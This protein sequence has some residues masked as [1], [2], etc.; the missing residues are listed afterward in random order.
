[1][2]TPFQMWLSGE[3]SLSCLDAAVEAWH[4]QDTVVAKDD[5][6]ELELFEAWWDRTFVGVPMSDIEHDTAKMAWM[7]RAALSSDTLSQ[8]LGMSKEEF[9]LFAF[10]PREFEAKY[11]YGSV[12]P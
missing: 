2:K 7:Q 4:E 1:M 3:G 12:K 11:P 6:A 10:D 8:C 5:P 9:A